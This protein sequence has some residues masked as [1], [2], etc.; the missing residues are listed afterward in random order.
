MTLPLWEGVFDQGSFSQCAAFDF[1]RTLHI[2][3]AS[4][5][6]LGL[7]VF[8]F[9]AASWN[10]SL[11]DPR[12]RSLS[13]CPV[14]GLKIFILTHIIGCQALE[15]FF[16]YTIRYKGGPAHRDIHHTQRVSSVFHES[17][18]SNYLCPDYSPTVFLSRNST[19]CIRLACL[20]H[21]FSLAHPYLQSRKFFR[22]ARK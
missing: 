2:E 18:N 20:V 16:S 22:N 15:E 19:C 7:I 5:F 21:T 4:I 1:I 6:P 10:R 17:G 14:N 11:G 9:F 12:A 8:T 3:A 13:H